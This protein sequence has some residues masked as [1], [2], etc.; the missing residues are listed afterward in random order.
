MLKRM[1]AHLGGVLFSPVLVAGQKSIG[2]PETARM[3]TSSL[4]FTQDVLSIAK[5]YRHG[6]VTPVPR[7]G[8]EL[9][10]WLSRKRHNHWNPHGGT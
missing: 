3:S 1:A 8:S 6:L 5:I 4:P 9:L 10:K 7:L 2:T